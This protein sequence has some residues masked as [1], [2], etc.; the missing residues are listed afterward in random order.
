MSSYGRLSTDIDVLA[1][2]I[3][4]FNS[5]IRKLKDLTS[6]SQSRGSPATISEEFEACLKT[7][8]ELQA[9]FRR[10]SPNRA[11]K[12]Q[13]DKLFSEFQALTKAFESIN[14][15][16][17]TSKVEV[18]RE[19][20]EE[21]EEDP[22]MMKIKTVGHL[23]DVALRERDETIA[24]VEKDMNE[25]NSMFREA[26]EMIVEQGVVL[27]EADRNMEVSVKETKRAAD[28]MGEANKL[29]QKAK[30]KLV[31]MCILIVVVLV[32]VSLVVL[33]YLYF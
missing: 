9:M 20:V 7:Q 11:S 10:N 6:S 26:G 25:L 32:L 5:R 28:D 13:H 19:K 2:M 1:G 17:S 33:G 29:Q 3:R 23:N 21:E 8:K 24:Q 12:S 4:E 30:D 22:E 27:E 14:K 18:L 15:N 31:L 16:V